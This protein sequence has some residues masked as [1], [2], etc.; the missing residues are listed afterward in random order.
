MGQYAVVHQFFVGFRNTD[1]RRPYRAI[2]IERLFVEIIEKRAQG[3][4]IVL[5]GWIELMI[6]ADCA[7][8]SKS[9]ECGAECFRALTCDVDAQLLGNCAT[10]V[11]ADTQS[12]I[13]AADQGIDS[14]HWHQV[15]S[16]LLDGKLI[17]G[18]VAVER[19]DHIIAVRPDVTA[20]VE[21]Q[22][23]SIG[24]PGVV[25]PVA[26]ALFPESRPSEQSVDKMLVCVRRR[27]V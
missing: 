1:D 16:D 14:F 10:F 26:C 2:V 15:A 9:H 19:A 21:M 8:H 11:A 20:V 17:E 27:V 25:E 5:S 22:T 13:T 4:E 7:T 23:V 18:L 12:H 24:V 3:I 6:V